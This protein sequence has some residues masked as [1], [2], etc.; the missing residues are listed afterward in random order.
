MGLFIRTFLK[1]EK[2][3]LLNYILSIG[4]LGRCAAKKF[5]LKNEGH[6]I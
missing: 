6:Q 3:Y 4:L 2:N 1:P 5:I